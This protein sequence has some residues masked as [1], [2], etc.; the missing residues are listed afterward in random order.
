MLPVAAQVGA[1]GVIG[2]CYEYR[3]NLG[4]PKGAEPGPRTNRRGTEHGH[5]DLHP[6]IDLGTV[7][8][9]V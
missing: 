4:N 8:N 7:Q 3:Q 9:G 2:V 1:N 6:A 5:A